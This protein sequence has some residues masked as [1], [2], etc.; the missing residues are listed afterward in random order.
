MLVA[1]SRGKW[2]LLKLRCVRTLS[3][4]IVGVSSG[5]LHCDE[6]LVHPR[7]YDHREGAVGAQLR[8]R[9]IAGTAGFGGHG[10][11][12]MTL[13]RYF[14]ALP[15]V[16]MFQRRC[17]GQ[18]DALRPDIQRQKAWQIHLTHENTAWLKLWHLGV[19]DW[20]FGAFA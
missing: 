18:A 20:F 16:D 11:T 10:P 12:T 2:K 9:T 4:V 1:R 5:E 15:G 7:V 13:Q 8:T 6:R 14:V 17:G 3:A 19:V